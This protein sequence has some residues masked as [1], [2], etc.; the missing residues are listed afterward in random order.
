MIEVIIAGI[1]IGIAGIKAQELKPKKVPIR[2][3]DESTKKRK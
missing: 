3:K 1:L 2:I